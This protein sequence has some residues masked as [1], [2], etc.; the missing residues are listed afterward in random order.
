MEKRTRPVDTVCLYPRAFLSI[1]W[2]EY[3]ERDTGVDCLCADFVGHERVAEFKEL[4]SLQ[5]RFQCSLSLRGRL[6]A[7]VLQ[8]SRIG[9]CDSFASSFIDF[10]VACLLLHSQKMGV[11]KGSYQLSVSLDA[12]RLHPSLH[13]PRYAGLPA[14]LHAK[15]PNLAKSIY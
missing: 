6:V 1:I 3:S 11:A 13:A 4:G 7:G 12:L 8:H 9:G 5:P 2:H 15:S 14:S 10:T